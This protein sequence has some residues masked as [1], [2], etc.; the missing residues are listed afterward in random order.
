[1]NR[2][3]VDFDTVESIKPDQQFELAAIPAERSAIK[4]MPEYLTKVSK[5]TNVRTLVLFFP[6]NFTRDQDESTR[7]NYI[8]L[9]GEWTAV[10]SN[11]GL[12]TR[13]LRGILSL[14]SMK[15]LPI[16]QAST[17][18]FFSNVDHKVKEDNVTSHTII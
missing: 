1:M 9:K 16:L 11:D 13:S 2:D 18:S 7:I 10:G 6:H 4:Q 12:L 3:D 5:F 14:P 17:T 15:H 8:G